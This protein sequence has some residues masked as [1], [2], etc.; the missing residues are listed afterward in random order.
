MKVFVLSNY[1]NIFFKR[2]YNSHW[3][4]TIEH[5][6]KVKERLSQKT[7]KD[8]CRSHITWKHQQKWWK[9]NKFFGQNKLTS[10]RNMRKMRGSWNGHHGG[11]E[12]WVDPAW[13]LPL[14]IHPLIDGFLALAPK[15]HCI[16]NHSYFEI[17]RNPPKKN[18]QKYL[19]EF[20]SLPCCWP[21]I[22]ILWDMVTFN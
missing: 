11:V 8:I 2:S 3:K 12:L 6:F 19:Q 22:L 5:I 13:W 14:A 21:Q 9:F 10:K 16:D 1:E 17:I 15:Q 7:D 20:F 18:L 4:N